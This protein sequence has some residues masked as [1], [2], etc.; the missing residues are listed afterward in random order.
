MIIRRISELKGAGI[1]SNYVA[2]K[3]VNMAPRTLI[4]GFNGSGKTTLSRVFSSIQHGTMEERLPS[5]TTFKVEAS[6][7]TQISHELAGAVFGNNLLIF[8]TDFVSRNF[9]WDSSTT[10]GIAYLS[11]K[12]VGAKKEFDENVA[13]VVAAQLRNVASKK[14]KAKADTAVSD[15]KTKVARN[16]REVA[17][18][19]T[20][21]QS[22]DARKIQSHY[23]AKK[24]PPD[25]QLSDEDLKINQAILGLKEPLP[26]LPFEVELD[27][28]LVEWFQSGQELLLS[29]ISSKAM[30]EFETHTSVLRWVQDGLNY[31][32]SHE[33]KDCLLCGN[34]F[35]DDRRGELR[36]IFD[37]SWTDAI[38]A[39]SEAVE[40]G[41]LSQETL[42]E[43]YRSIPKESDVFSEQRQAFAEVRRK[44]V[45][46]ITQL[47]TCIGELITA[48][49]SKLANPTSK[50]LGEGELENFNLNLWVSEFSQISVAVTNIINVHNEASSSFATLQSV[51]FSKIENHI[52]ATNQI[53]W[54]ELLLEEKTAADEK[55]KAHSEEHNLKEKQLAL[56][57]ELHDHGVGADKLNSLIWA[58]LGHTDLGLQAEDGGYKIV[59]TGGAAAKQLSEGERTAISFCYFLTLLDAE[60]RKREDLILVI[61]DPISS[62]D[63]AARTH[64]YSLMTRNTKKCAQ[65]IVLTHNTSFMNMVKRDFVN[66]QSRHPTVVVTA[67]LTLDCRSIAATGARATTLQI[68]PELLVKFNSEYHYLFQLVRRAAE[69]KNT[70]YL[71]LLPNATRKLLEMFA[72]FC[73]PDKPGFTEALMDHHEEVKDVVDVKALERLVQIES[74]GTIEGM[75]SLPNLTLEEAIRAADAAMKFIKAIAKSHYRKMCNVCN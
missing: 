1:W 12:K 37:Q 10:N 49:R 40:Q 9:Q 48:L 43:Y 45:A 30:K 71:F 38:D 46:V 31:H 35:S 13:K 56:Q 2:P 18:S 21:T 68:M 29:S 61:D 3:D 34:I 62:L 39:L 26:K 64:A 15:F 73:S 54:D 14:A 25:M 66:L 60:G 20:Y 36:S 67:L 32:E 8:N 51:A 6:D 41:T 11:E 24:F 5:G 53:E 69:S 19:A 74:H 33:L 44:L 16:V 27:D 47:G 63:T 65:L 59:R 42:R 75:G 70:E 4:Y 22:Y 28:G 72:T 7:G 23:A 17:S 55:E 57:N 50:I 52:L 58:Y